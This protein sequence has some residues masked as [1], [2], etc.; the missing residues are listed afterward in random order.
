MLNHIHFQK[1]AGSGTEMCSSESVT[2]TFF[3][4][5]FHGIRLSVVKILVKGHF[6]GL[7]VRWCRVG[8]WFRGDSV[9]SDVRWYHSGKSDVRWDFGDTDVRGALVC[10]GNYVDFDVS[11]DYDVK[12]AL[13]WLLHSLC[14]MFFYLLMTLKY[15][16]HAVNSTEQDVHCLNCCWF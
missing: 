3:E 1:L 15:I 6:A 4:K 10:R 2:R 11:K 5:S 9:D 12:M 14:Y 13:I 16:H 8:L 7:D